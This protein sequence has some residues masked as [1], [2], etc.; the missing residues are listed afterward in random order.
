MEERKISL[1]TMSAGNPNA[2]RKTLESFKGVVDEVIFG[3]LI[4]FETDRFEIEKMATEFNIKMHQLPFNYIFQMGFSSVLNYLISNAKNDMVLYSNVGEYIQEDYGINEIINSNHECNMFYFKHA[5]ET[6]RWYRCFDRSF[7]QWSGRLHEEPR[8]NEY[9]YHKPIYC[10]ADSEKDMDNPFKAAVLNSCKEI[11]YWNQL[12][13]I[14]D[15]PKLKEATNEHWVNFA[16]QEYQSMK[17]RLEKKGKQYEAFKIGDF[18]MFIED[19]HTSKYFEETEF[20]SGGG[21]NFQG[22]RK[23]IL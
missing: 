14:V 3:D 17:D 8:G 16:K 22:A 15:N 21:L 12:I 4:I 18:K 20:V 1:I 10:M 19:I 6:H 23:D 5:V 9:P 11:V 7:V 2:L 13:K